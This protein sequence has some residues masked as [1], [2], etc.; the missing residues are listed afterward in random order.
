MALKVPFLWVWGWG[1][2]RLRGSLR[3]L[4]RVQKEKRDRN[5]LRGVKP[6]TVTT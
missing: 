2:G 3:R 5:S 4:E 1:G 6:T